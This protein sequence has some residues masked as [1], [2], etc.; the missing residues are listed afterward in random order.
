M[1]AAVT[2][3]AGRRQAGS[4]LKQAA[5]ERT[6]PALVGTRACSSI[7]IRR[8]WM[9]RN[10]SCGKS[11]SLTDP[12]QTRGGRLPS[13]LDGELVM[14]EEEGMSQMDGNGRRMVG[15]LTSTASTHLE[16]GTS[17]QLTCRLRRGCVC[18]GL[19]RAERSPVPMPTSATL[20]L[21]GCWRP[22]VHFRQTAPS[23]AAD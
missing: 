9:G 21:P 2:P 11:I 23:A 18:C 12:L 19:R 17:Q 4:W 13:M 1:T 7:A 15:Q 3:A 10:V 20:V 16:R 6:K 22:T 8:W 14:G 5:S